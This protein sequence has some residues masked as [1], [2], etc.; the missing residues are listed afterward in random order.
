VLL[1][2]IRLINGVI[3]LAAPHMIIKRFTGGEEDPPVAR[4]ALRMFGIRTILIAIDLL[5]PD[6]E[7]RRHAVRVAPLIHGSD[8]VAAILAAKS[9][10]VPK[11]TGMLIV[12]ISGLNTLLAIAMQG[13]RKH[14]AADAD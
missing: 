10:R 9:P 6:S 14:P 12:A 3:A 2:L 13:E 4:Y 8:L 11:Q 7:K 5:L 1:A